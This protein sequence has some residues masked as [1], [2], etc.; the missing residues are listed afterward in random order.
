VLQA[1]HP[2][3]QVPTGD[4]LLAVE[5]RGPAAW[6]REVRVRPILAT[7][8]ED[9]GDAAREQPAAADPGHAIS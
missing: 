1:P 7:H 2:A 4:L 3:Q 9:A 8:E 6:I 5:V